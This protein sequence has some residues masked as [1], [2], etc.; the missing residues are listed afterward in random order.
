MK[1]IKGSPPS[2][3]QRFGFP[4][5]KL[6]IYNIKNHLFILCFNFHVENNI[7]CYKLSAYHL[8]GSVRANRIQ[9]KRDPT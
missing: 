5:E 9:K 6:S 3:R 1:I 2:R 4:S 7:N 8:S